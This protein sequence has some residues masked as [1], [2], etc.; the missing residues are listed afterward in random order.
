MGKGASC[1]TVHAEVAKDVLCE[2]VLILPSLKE[3]VKVRKNCLV[4]ILD[5]LA[6]KGIRL[7]RL[8]PGLELIIKSRADLGD[9]R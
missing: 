3:L 8:D 6:R 7:D 2:Y 5:V 9:L 4:P 1:G